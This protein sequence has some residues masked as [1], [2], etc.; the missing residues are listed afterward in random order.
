MFTWDT[1][2]FSF[3]TKLN[4]RS[5]LNHCKNQRKK[6]IIVDRG[7]ARQYINTDN[8]RKNTHHQGGYKKQTDIDS[9][10][11]CILVPPDVD[12]SIQF[13]DAKKLKAPAQR[14]ARSTDVEF[15]SLKDTVPETTDDYL[16]SHGIATDICF[17]RKEQE[18]AIFI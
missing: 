5:S 2:A 4:V 15:L 14:S 3:S 16:C 11:S 9:S 1:R 18:K 13:L 12:C 8:S 6:V 10:R 17:R 7:F